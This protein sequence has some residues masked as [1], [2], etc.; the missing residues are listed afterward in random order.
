MKPELSVVVVGDGAG[1]LR[2]LL[3]ALDA[4]T[5][6]SKMELVV[7]APAAAHQAIGEA[8]PRGLAGFQF[9]DRTP[10]KA[11]APAKSDAVRAARADVVVFTETHAFPFP[12]WAAALIAAH[13]H[14]RCAAVGPELI[15]ANPRPLS[16]ANMLLD[17][18]PFIADGQRDLG[19]VLDLPGHNSS[20]RREL[21]LDYGERLTQLLGFEAELHADL[22]RR[23]ERMVLEPR[24]RLSHVNVTRLRSW[25]P[26]RW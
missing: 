13:R 20:Y 11:F 19:E 4:Q 22:R 25:L 16:R 23:G 24:A 2:P 8:L 1:R 6:K 12:G 26:E 3:A 9:V 10:L 7:V 17:Y 5:A 15:N 21:L 14:E 18:G